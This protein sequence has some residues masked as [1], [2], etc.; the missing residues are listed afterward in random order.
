MLFR[1]VAMVFIYKK[2]GKEVEL[3]TEQISTIDSTY[4]FVDRKD[5]VIREGDK[6]PI[7]DFTITAADGT[8]LTQ[9]ILSLDKVFI[10]VAY[11]INH[12]DKGVQGKVNDFVALAQRDGIEF[13]G[14]TSSVPA[15]VDKFKAANGTKHEYYF[16]DATTLKTMIRSNPGLMLLKKGTVVAMWHH[17]DFPSYDDVKKTLLSN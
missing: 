17:N 16:T 2:D 6:P 15:D 8:D 10:L 14:L 1:S 13:A 12:A 4:T 7:H 5:K 3:T 9:D 11:D